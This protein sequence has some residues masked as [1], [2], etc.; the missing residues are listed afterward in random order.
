MK[1]LLAR[2]LPY[3]VSEQ[4]LS[5]AEDGRACRALTSTHILRANVMDAAEKREHRGR[6]DTLVEMNSFS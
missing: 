3:V 4:P 1:P 5:A 2:F 6:N